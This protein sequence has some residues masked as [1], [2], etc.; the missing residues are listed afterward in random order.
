MSWSEWKEINEKM[1]QLIHTYDPE[2]IPLVAGFNWAYDLTPLHFEPIEAEG[3]GYV[4]HPYPMKHKAPW[5]EKW[6]E[7]FGFAAG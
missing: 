5:P 3:I 2:V 4:T 6:E 1:I 7:N